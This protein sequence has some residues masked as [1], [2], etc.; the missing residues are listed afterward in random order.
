MNKEKSTNILVVDDERTSRELLKKM[1]ERKGFRVVTAAN[2]EEGLARVLA[3][4]IQVVL[5]DIVMPRLN[6]IEFLKKVK[7]CLTVQV[8]MITGQADVARCL[9]SLQHGACGYLLKPIHI[10]ELLKL[11]NHAKRNILER[12]QI[13]DSAFGTKRKQRPARAA[14]R[15]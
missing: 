14:K 9:L 3:D 6:G 8:I 15:R 13:F 7:D 4:N 1:L 5:C 2:G 12:K 10:E 11:I